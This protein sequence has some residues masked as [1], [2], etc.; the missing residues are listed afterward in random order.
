MTANRSE[1]RFGNNTYAEIVITKINE[2]YDFCV[3]C[4]RCHYLRSPKSVMKL[5]ENSDRYLEGHV[6][7]YCSHVSCCS[8]E[9]TGRVLFYAFVD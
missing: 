1:H 8:C 9:T 6:D 3:P 5:E 7:V 4:I 2:L